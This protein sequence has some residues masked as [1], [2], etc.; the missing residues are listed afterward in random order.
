MLKYSFTSRPF[1]CTSASTLTPY[2]N[3]MPRSV[4]PCATTWTIGVGDGV[5]VNVAVGGIGVR[6]PLGDN[7]E[8]V[9]KVGVTV[10]KGVAVGGGVT[11]A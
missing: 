11:T 8:V 2:S 10:G 5:G 1:A 9:R 4:F 7:A 6:K 3:A